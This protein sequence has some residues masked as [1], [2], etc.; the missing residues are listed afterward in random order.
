M[1]LLNNVVLTTATYRSTEDGE[2]W[3]FSSLGVWL[4]ALSIILAIL[5]L[6]ISVLLLFTEKMPPKIVQTLRIKEFQKKVRF[7]EPL[8]SSKIG[9]TGM[10]ATMS[11]LMVLLFVAT[12]F[13]LS[14]MATKEDHLVQNIQQKYAVDSIQWSQKLP[15]LYSLKDTLEA[16]VAKGDKTYK[17][18]VTQNPNT[19]EP[20]LLMI[21]KATTELTELLK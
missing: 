8:K 5:V 15:A 12:G 17:V 9:M 2:R 19:Y 14:S 7:E 21:P 20:T 10:D 4:L 3:S 11:C 13:G 1:N 6:L 18:T 16:T